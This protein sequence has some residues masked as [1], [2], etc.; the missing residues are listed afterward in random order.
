MKK[1]IFVH[2]Y[3]SSPRKK[4]YQ[5]ISKELTKL[6]IPCSMPQLPGGEHSKSDEWLNIINRE[7]ELSNMPVVLIG[8]SLGTRAALLY[9]DK[10]NQKVD[11]VI[12][13]ASFNNNVEEN[14]ERKNGNY[15]SFWE[16]KLDIDKIKK[17][18][19]KFVVVH[20]KDD[21]SI[22][23]QQGVEIANDLGA[24]LIT[25]DDFQHFSGEENAEKNAA[26][27]L[28]IIKRYL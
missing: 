15:N 2:G 16:Y 3:T 19:N 21:N 28:K 1:I 17:L 26:E 22:N 8:H 20:S 24:E 5:I 23:Y 27:W 12:L 11:T 18:A 14:R 7:V 10:F 13:I 9:L 6:N 4:K 25:Y